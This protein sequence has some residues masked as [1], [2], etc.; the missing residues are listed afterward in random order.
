MD[1]PPGIAELSIVSVG[2]D[3]C[4]AVSGSA[5][6]PVASAAGKS[7]F[8]LPPSLPTQPGPNG[9]LF[10]F[11]DGCRVQVPADRDY[12]VVLRDLNTNNILFN[13]TG[14]GS[15]VRSAKK[16]YVRF[17]IEVRATDG[18]LLFAHKFD[19]RD[20]NVLINLPVGTIGD[21]LG[22][23]PY[24]AR[25]QQLHGCRLTCAMS[26]LL[27]PL[28]ETAYPDVT[29]V[30]HEAVRP[31][32]FYATYNIGLFF[33]DENYER[34]PTDFRMVGLHRTAAYILGV[35]PAEAP[36]QLALPD[37]T[38]PIEEPYVCIAVQASTHAK[39][40]NNP[41]GWAEI[42]RFLKQAGYRV[43]CI[44]R[45]TAHG[46]GLAWSYIPHGSEDE[47]GARPLTER[48]RWLRHASAFIGVSSGLAWL[49]WAAGCPVVMISGFTHPTNEFATPGRVINWHACNSCWNDT[50]HR[51]E[52]KD[53]LWCPRH[54]GTARQFECTRLIT[55]EQVKLALHAIGLRSLD[56]PAC[57][58][59]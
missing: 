30:T 28:L 56:N 4:T 58:S 31:E 52:H 13:S 41:H 43:I 6:K 29:F 12:V 57:L 9:I 35:D 18:E 54:A 19:A 10:D 23:F 51:F 20:K 27:I 24:V 46:A 36:P 59:L 33:D 40:W 1:G 2:M 14:R 55:S 32:D 38:R 21:T 11:N 50:Q 49:A 39:K 45:E 48:A 3:Q 42:V 8:P 7:S 22:W 15:R 16:F 5:S 17:G 37:E 53:Y 44:D 34:Q 25:F 47:T 26:A